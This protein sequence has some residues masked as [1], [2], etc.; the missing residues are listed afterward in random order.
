MLAGAK[1]RGEFE[2][3]LE[4]VVKEVK[5]GNGM[6]LLFL[7]EIHTLVGAGGGNLDA[8]NILKPAL[9]RGEIR[10]IGATTIEEYRTTI[11][12]DKALE[13]RF[14]QVEVKEPD[15]AMAIAMLQALVPKLE[16][17]FG[18]RIHGDA[19]ETAVK[20]S[21]R[22]IWGQYLPDK[23]RDLLE[24]ACA[25]QKFEAE[26]FP[27]ELQMLEARSVELQEKLRLNEDTSSEEHK[28]LATQLDAHHQ[29]YGPRRTQWLLEKEA[30]RELGAVRAEI[31]KLG[32]DRKRALRHGDTAKS[33]QLRAKLDELR[34]RIEETEAKLA[35]VTESKRHLTWSISTDEV[36]KA[37]EKRTG[38][39]VGR[40][41]EDD[42]QRLLQL[43]ATLAGSVIGQEDAIQG[44][45][46]AVHRSRAGVSPVNRPIGNLLFLGPTGVGKTHLAKTLAKELFGRDDALIRIDMSEY[47]DKASHT[48]LVGA[49]PGYVGYDA[50]GQLTE[51]IRRRPFSV[52]LFDEMEKAHEDILLMLLQ[53]T[54]E[55]KLTDGR[56][57][58]FD[59][60]NALV[61]FTSNIGAAQV[62]ASIAQGE[63]ALDRRKEAYL[64][65][66]K[67]RL[68]Q[69]FLGRLDVVVF[70]RLGPETVT[71][72]VRR[73][74]KLLAKRLE[75]NGRIEL[76]W[77][78]AVE[79]HLAS[80]YDDTFGAR[81]VLSRIRSDAELPIARHLIQRDAP[82]GEPMALHLDHS[83][84]SG[85]FLSEQAR[86]S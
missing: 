9:A 47:Q 80:F 20:L 66:V 85:L 41:M 75:D 6:I 67:R 36:A 32:E 59:F 83:S 29:E 18:L 61:I 48:R 26:T 42:R 49:P 43:H 40:L 8:A 39:P 51:A 52:I 56:G 17:H 15:D 82:Q 76:R 44:I 57:V 12:N 58:T 50:G 28:T 68:R 4:G 11:Q 27:E 63:V 71:G 62:E 84:S 70:N 34:G 1:Y 65:I 78:E 10:C 5:A 46:D 53:L 73:E 54:D 21:R 81:S 55:A 60:S 14:T 38:I 79:E 13:R 77:A 86:R 33:A 7:D 3:R 16:A 31:A 30:G 72:L 37:V 22:Y 24:L 74:L 64:E 45:V 69:E 19:I 23:G 35:S 25:L 2:E